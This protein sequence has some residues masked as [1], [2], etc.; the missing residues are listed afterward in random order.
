MV[1]NENATELCSDLKS[2]TISAVE[3][4]EETYDRIEAHNPVVNAITNLLDRNEAIC[5]AKVADRLPINKRGLLH[6]LP[7]AP[8]DLIDVK[9]FP[10]TSG[11]R[12]FAKRIAHTDHE[13]VRRMRK[14]GALF[15]G[16]T[17]VPEFG[18]GSN[19]F[20]EV[21]GQSLNPYDLSKTPGGSSGGAA[22]ALATRMLAL[23]DGSDMGGSLRNPASFCNVVG[24]R[25]SIG[26]QPNGKGFGWYGR[27]STTGPM[28]R[29]VSDTAYLMAS[30]GGPDKQDPLT[31]PEDGN[32]FLELLNTPIDMST[33]KVAYCPDLH[34]L[35]IDPEVRQIISNAAGIFED[36]GCTVVE[37]GPDLSRAMEVFQIQR[38]AGLALLGNSLEASVP[39]WRKYTKK[40][41]LWN[42]EKGQDLTAQEILKTE[43]LRNQIYSNAVDFMDS[44]D[45]IILPAAQVPAFDI[46]TEWVKEI[47]GKLMETYIDWMTVCCAVTVTG[48]PAISVPAGFTADKLPV[49]VQIVGKPKG[50]FELLRIAHAYELATGHYKTKPP[51]GS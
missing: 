3:V 40:T 34:G 22:I 27:L 46:D 15:I 25:P 21:F 48:F 18:L 38:A 42:I 24:Y 29:T 8:K 30:I 2:G 32:Q 1:M 10:S 9:G 50:D 51:V 11:Y 12:P 17:N 39:D 44:Y 31:L 26:R 43:I 19:T 7:M 13:I 5:L 33:V 28:A 35:P 6:G 47:D 23:C 20:N 41:A 45:V 37:T 49:G 16:H 4:M 36:L 14:A